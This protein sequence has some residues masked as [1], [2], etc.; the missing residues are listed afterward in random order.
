MNDGG[1]LLHIT[2]MGMSSTTNPR[3]SPNN[4]KG[5]SINR[6][7]YLCVMGERNNPYIY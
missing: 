1:A 3:I 5:D 2:R 4:P 6:H 7:I